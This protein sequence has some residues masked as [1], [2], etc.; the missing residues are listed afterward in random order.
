M[1][2]AAK[3]GRE[4]HTFFPLEYEL[5]LEMVRPSKQLL[6]GPAVPPG[7]LL[8]QFQRC[9]PTFVWVDSRSLKPLE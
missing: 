7:Y 9:E 3:T 8:R 2:R 6:E 4:G 5:Q 1:E